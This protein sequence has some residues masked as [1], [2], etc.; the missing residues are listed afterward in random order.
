MF[1][2]IPV[3]PN[4]TDDM[5]V[6]EAP[7]FVVPY[8]YE[9]P[10]KE[11]FKD[12]KESLEKIIQDLQEKAKIEKKKEEEKEDVEMEDKDKETKEKED[13]EMEDKEGKE[14]EEGD[15]ETKEKEEGDKETKEE[16]K[17]KKADEVTVVP[18]PKPAP[19]VLNPY[20]ETSVGKF[21][22]D[23]GMNMVQEMVQQDL[24]KELTKKSAKDKS[25]QMM[26]N[27]A[28][29]KSNLV[30]KYVYILLVNS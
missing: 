8:V 5:F 13:V 7:S 18:V 11:S 12:F 25:A 22:V 16:E 19:V 21:V 28:S 30:I 1:Q 9:K 2:A 3:D 6:L 24:L 26:R 27:I 10:A 4:L 29:L 15:K 20:F 14:K 23:L 17:E